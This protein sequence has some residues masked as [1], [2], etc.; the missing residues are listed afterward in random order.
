VNP[1]SL[2]RKLFVRSVFMIVVLRISAEAQDPRAKP[3]Q[4]PIF[5]YELLS[6]GNEL[7]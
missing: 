5:P 1:T 6:A 3:F 7:E 2:K 4:M